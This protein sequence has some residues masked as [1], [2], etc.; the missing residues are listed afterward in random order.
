[1][2][3][4]KNLPPSLIG[5]WHQRGFGFRRSL[6]IDSIA[7]TRQNLMPRHDDEARAS[8]Q[9]TGTG[10]SPPAGT[11]CPA[12]IRGAAQQ[13]RGKSAIPQGCPAP[14]PV[15]GGVVPSGTGTAVSGGTGL[16]TRVANGTVASTGF[17]LPVGTGVASRLSLAG[18][19]APTASSESHRGRFA[20]P[21]G[22]GI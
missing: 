3:L 10:V 14:Y 17:P 8:L 18:T 16:P 6:G 7:D 21:Y 15:S 11:G 22:Y 4:D 5:S 9:P 2:H 20:L 13:N 12:P 19:A 1:M